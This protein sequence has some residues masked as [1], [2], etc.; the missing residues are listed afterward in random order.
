MAAPIPQSTDVAAPSVDRATADLFAAMDP[1]ADITVLQRA[2]QE[3]GS[4]K[5]TARTMLPFAADLTPKA[6]QLCALLQA[7]DF[8]SRPAALRA[9][10]VHQSVSRSIYASNH[11]EHLSTE[12]VQ[13][14][15]RCVESFWKTGSVD[16]VSAANKEHVVNA[17]KLMGDTY[18]SSHLGCADPQTQL[19][20]DTPTLLKWHSTLMVGGTDAAARA[21]DFIAGRIREAGART[22]DG[23]RTYPHHSVL[24]KGL[25]QLGA[26]HHALWKDVAC[27]M[28]LQHG[29]H[30]RVQW[31]LALAAF[32][33]FH[34]VDLHPFADGNGRMCRF[35]SKRA[36]DWVL[37]VPLPMFTGRE[38]YFHT[39]IAGGKEQRALHAPRLLAELMLDE[40]I[41]YFREQLA[42]VERAPFD[43]MI[44]ADCAEELQALTSDLSSE[45]RALLSQ[46]FHSLHANE[47][48]LVTVDAKLIRLIRYPELALDDI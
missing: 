45:G 14:T 10:L 41:A 4:D 12:S 40:A 20:W 5:V 35:L 6:K 27:G 18:K 47:H 38:D 21:T 37:P 30:G 24:S 39:L 33:Q 2:I 17:L 13:D 8:A 42:I 16:G 7:L 34:F 19:A 43:R 1:G 31:C 44:V 3:H 46:S 32:V 36:L 9:N 26:L 22:A 29:S 25:A 48:A 15:E 23:T 11:I 28:G